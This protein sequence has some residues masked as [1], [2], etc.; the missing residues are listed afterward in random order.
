V[1]EQIIALGHELLFIGNADGMESRIIPSAGYEFAPIKVQKLYRKLTPRLI[2]FPWH[3]LS[4]TV[5]CIGLIRTFK[6]RAVFCTGGFVSG[7]VAAA[8]VLTRTPLFFHESNSLPGITTKAFSRFARVTYISFAGSR[9]YLR[10]NLIDTGVPL[11][12]RVQAHEDFD[13]KSLGLDGSKPIILIS[14]GS[15]GSE[16]I[17]KVVDNTMADILGMG[18]EVIWQTGKTG[19]KRLREKYSSAS[20]VF[21]FDFSDRLPQFYQCAFMAITRAGAMTLAE[22]EE[23]RLPAI[24]VPLPTAAENHQFVNAMA[25]QDKGFAIVLEQKNLNPASLMDAIKTIQTKHEAY[26]GALA[27]LPPNTAARDVTVHMIKCLDKGR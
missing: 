10:G 23:N 19:Y 24:L 18:F 27:K 20:G 7:P 16:S 21:I 11:L 2:T 5:K 17:N 1:A 4:S 3:L 12:S 13:P 14:G 15:Q 6:P 9:K 26:T 25:Q 22:L 8:A